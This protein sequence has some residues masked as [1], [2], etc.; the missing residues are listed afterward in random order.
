MRV[1]ERLDADVLV[2]PETWVPHEGTGIVEELKAA[3]Y[4]VAVDRWITLRLV[5]PRMPAAVPGDGW[6]SLAVASRLP[7]LGRRDIPMPRAFL[8]RAHPRVAISVTLDVGGTAVDVVGLH[9]SSRLWWG[10]PWVHITGLRRELPGN[11]GPALA[12]GDFNMWGPEVERMLPG[13]R[14]TVVGRTYPSHRPHSQIDHVLV[15]DWL[16]MV[17]GEVVDDRQSDHR[18]VRVVLRTRSAPGYAFGR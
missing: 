9:T 14:R 4:E 7:V 5:G 15:N 13:W 8:D 3:G 11:D 18:P 16:E 2:L 6:W 1:L 10:A 12:A 17:S